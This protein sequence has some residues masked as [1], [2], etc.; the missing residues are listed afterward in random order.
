MAQSHTVQPTSISLGVRVPS[1]QP[2]VARTLRSMM[3]VG[4][5]REPEQYI[6]PCVSLMGPE[7]L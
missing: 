5:L 4:L 6:S 3:V 7:R 1:S 2:Y